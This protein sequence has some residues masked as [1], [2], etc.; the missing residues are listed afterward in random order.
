MT[1][2]ELCA[3]TPFPSELPESLK[4]SVEGILAAARENFEKSEY[5]LP[6]FYV[7]NSA[8]N[9]TALVATPFTSQDPNDKRAVA[10][11]VKKIARDMDADSLVFV[12]ESWAVRPEDAKEFMENRDKYPNVRDFPKRIDVLSLLIESNF[13][14]FHGSI[15]TTGRKVTGTLHFQRTDKST[16]IFSNLLPPP[17]TMN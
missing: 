8:K 1:D 10:W 9:E 3:T 12:S 16:G 13:G 7:S 15:E 5:L 6:M 4:K 17:R 14:N 11:Q 2:A